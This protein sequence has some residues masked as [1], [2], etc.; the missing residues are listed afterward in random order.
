MKQFILFQTKNQSLEP[1]YYYSSRQI[2]SLRSSA[3]ALFNHMLYECT[4][5]SGQD[6]YGLLN[7]QVKVNR[8]FSLSAG[9]LEVCAAHRVNVRWAPSPAAAVKK[10][11]TWPRCPELDINWISRM[12][13]G[14]RCRH[15]TRC[16]SLLAV[17]Y[18]SGHF[19]VW[20]G[21]TGVWVNDAQRHHEQQGETSVINYAMTQR[22]RQSSPAAEFGVRLFKDSPA[23][24]SPRITA[25]L[26]AGSERPWTPAI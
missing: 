21:S 4:N 7:Y 1:K 25:A 16:F 8:H 26:Q 17:T 24:E 12:T 13:A 2:S 22:W 14:I 9:D 18:I 23:L 3:A 20:W 6:D 10:R 19:T 5:F 11:R 15:G